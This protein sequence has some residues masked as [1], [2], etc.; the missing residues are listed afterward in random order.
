MFQANGRG[1]G[2]DL[3]LSASYKKWKLGM[4]VTDIGHIKWQ[5]IDFTPTT[6]KFPTNYDSLRN[7]IQNNAKI[8]N[9]FYNQSPGPDY[10]NQLPTKFRLGL[11]YQ[12]TKG[13]GFSSDFVAP[14][15][16]VPGNLLKPYIAACTQINVFHYIELNVG[17]AT[18]SQFN[19]V[20]PV[21]VFVNFIGGFDFYV[22]TND[23]T[24]FLNNY[25]GHVLSAAAG[26]RI[27]G[28]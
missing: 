14:L 16:S 9:Y 27:C 3:G 15:N 4:S 24:A 5:N 22:G 11:S 6:I 18:E 23:A 19:Y 10:T 26:I 20:V 21:G 7:Y 28:F 12:L 8:L 1:L 25:S 13:I 17:I 2:I